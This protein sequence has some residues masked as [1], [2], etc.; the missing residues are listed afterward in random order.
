MPENLPEKYRSKSEILLY[1]TEDGKSRI[2]VR[3][4]SGTVWLSQRLMAELFQTTVANV[5]LH[6]R[7]LFQEG[8]LDSEAVVKEYLITAA[9]GQRHV[10][11]LHCRPVA[12][13]WSG[14]RCGVRGDCV[15]VTALAHPDRHKQR[16]F[17]GTF[18]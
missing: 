4:E 6:L 3:L 11:E 1:T 18:H 5:D 2:Q 16:D 17:Y 9:D 8:E 15:L 12:S 13:P 10:T 14:F 7:N